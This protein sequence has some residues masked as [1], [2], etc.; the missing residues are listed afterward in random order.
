[1]GEIQYCND[2]LANDVIAILSKLKMHLWI[3]R[4]WKRNNTVLTNYAR[5]NDVFNN[6]YV[7]VVDTKRNQFIIELL[8]SNQNIISDIVIPE[9]WGEEY[10][11]DKNSRYYRGLYTDFKYEGK[12]YRLYEDIVMQITEEGETEGFIISDNETKESFIMKLKN[13]N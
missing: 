13:K 10:I 4:D 7:Y 12:T 11:E 9:A 3:L 6:G 8:L 1:M 5:R 2:K